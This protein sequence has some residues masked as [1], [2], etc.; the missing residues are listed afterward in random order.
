MQ[1][2]MLLLLQQSTFI[3]I[4]N[5]TKNLLKNTNKNLTTSPGSFIFY[6][7]MEANTATEEKHAPAQPAVTTEV[8]E[9]KPVKILAKLQLEKN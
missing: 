4:K 5:L 6:I 3:F 9:A 8:N 1:L 2:P 7:N